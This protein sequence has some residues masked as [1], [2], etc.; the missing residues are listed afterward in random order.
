[1]TLPLDVQRRCSVTF[2]SLINPLTSPT[3]ERACNSERRSAMSHAFDT[4]RTTQQFSIEE[5]Q[6]QQLKKNTL[7]SLMMILR[8]VVRH[9]RDLLVGPPLLIT[10]RSKRRVSSLFVRYVD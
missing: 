6:S 8:S 7:R 5:Q 4:T 10:E 3:G 9:I 1:M 2:P